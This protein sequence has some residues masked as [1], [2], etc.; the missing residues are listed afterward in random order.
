MIEPFKMAYT[1]IGGLGV[2]ILGMK[3]LSDS[4][5]MLSGSLIRKAISSLTT[6]RI[7]AVLVGLTVTTFVQSSTITTVMVV[8]LANAGLMQ[9]SQ[10]IGVILGANIGTT[11]TG[12]ILAVNIGKYGLLLIALGIFPMLFSKN[13]RISG[14]S[15]VLVALGLIFFGLEIMSGAFRPLRSHEGFMNLMLLLDARTLLSLLGCVV[16]GCLMTMVVQ[17]SSAMLGITIAL[18]ATGA[19][20]LHTAIALVMGENIGTTITAQLAAIGSTVNA[21]RSA[22]AHS[23]FNVLGVVI[24]ITVFSPYVSLIETIVPGAADFVNSEG[25]RP[26]IAA[27]IALAHTMFN[28]T[29]TLVILPFLGHLEKLVIRIVPET[30]RGEKGPFRYIGPPGSMPVAMG[31]SMVFE[32]LKQM[33]GRVHKALRHVGSLLHRDIKGRDRFLQKVKAIEEQTDVMQHEITTFTV[34]LMQ[35]GKSSKE[36]SDRAYAYVRAADELE[37]I[38]DY[39]ASICSYMKRLDKHEVDFSE[40]AWKDLIAFHQEVFAFFIQVCRSFRNEDCSGI[41]GMSD[42]AKRLNDLADA[43]RNA[44]LDRMKTGSCGA[45]PALTFSDMAVAL[46]RIKNHTVNLHEALFVGTSS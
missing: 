14:S 3:Y 2:F 4:L 22:M 21:R 43:I 19:I 40:E 44:H 45:L 38:A 11:I 10:A 32:E 7:M 17:S 33:Q 34:A 20:P 39:A 24:L 31:I 5:Q 13:E 28:V 29:A 46:H 16:I 42:R 35:A 9:L 18:A 26:Y 25:N 36:Q 12:W 1:A 27:H 23:L 8:G 30:G 6:N 37:S 41:R 15:K